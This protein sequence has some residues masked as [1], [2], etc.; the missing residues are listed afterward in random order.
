MAAVKTGE[1]RLKPLDISTA[2]RTFREVLDQVEPRPNDQGDQKQK[3]NYAEL[4]SNRIAVWLA[5]MLR[6]NKPKFRSILPNADGSGRETR[7]ASGASKKPKKTDVRF[8]TADT[9]VELLVSVKTLSFRDTKRDSRGRTVLGRYTKNMVRNDHELRAEAMDVHERFPYAVLVA[10]LFLP[11]TAC[12][13]GEA[14]KS[15]FAHAIKTFRARGGRVLPSDPYQQFER[16]FI[17]LYELEEQEGKRGEVR[18]F[19]V[20]TNP[21]RRG[22][23]THGLLTEQ[24][25]VMEITKAYEIRNEGYIEWADGAV[26]PGSESPVEEDADDLDGADEA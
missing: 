24:E 25:L 15:S 6:G 16:M 7:V 11:Y 17:G 19:D 22:R 2:P 14:D 12:D 20:M 23:P 9:G 8:S 10:I 18:F 4:L 5:E 21:P 3:K 26:P 1:P 13:D